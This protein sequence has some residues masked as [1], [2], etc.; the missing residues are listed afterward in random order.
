[1]SGA[2]TA[3]GVAELL[4]YPIAP[5]AGLLRVGKR[6]PLLRLVKTTQKQG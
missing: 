3:K 2:L 5:R 4:L 6:S 1:M